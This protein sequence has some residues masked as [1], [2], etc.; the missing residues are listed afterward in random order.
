M[1]PTL[2]PTP[3]FVAVSSLTVV[4]ESEMEIFVAND[5]NDLAIPPSLPGSFFIALL[6]NVDSLDLTS[7]LLLRTS[8][9]FVSFFLWLLFNE[10]VCVVLWSPPSLSGERISMPGDVF[11]A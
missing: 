2:M 6:W 7:T 10:L 3:L 11:L 1:Q 5:D 8:N 9:V 4:D